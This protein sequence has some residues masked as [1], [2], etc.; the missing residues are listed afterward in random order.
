MQ[1][2]LVKMSR[3]TDSMLGES[4]K[5]VFIALILKNQQVKQELEVK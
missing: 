4:K 5:R 1:Q 3:R 2:C